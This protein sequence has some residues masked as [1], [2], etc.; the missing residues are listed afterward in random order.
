[1]RQWQEMTMMMAG[2]PGKLE[3]SLIHA[4]TYRDH[5]DED[6]SDDDDEEEDQD[7]DEEGDNE[8]DEDDD[9]E[10][11]DDDRSDEEGD[12]DAADAEAG[13]RKD[14]GEEWCSANRGLACQ[15]TPMHQQQVH[16]LPSRLKNHLTYYVGGI[17]SLPTHLG[18][19]HF[20]STP[21]SEFPHPRPS[22]R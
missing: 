11:D 9:D 21:L 18:S 3:Y 13:P 4:E 10:E 6:G 15:L 17:S 2:E 22:T 1:M 5:S 19:P 16:H 20:P 14:G 7:D 8:D 12:G